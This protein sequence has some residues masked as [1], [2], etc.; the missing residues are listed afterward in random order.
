[1][2]L[3]L[4]ERVHDILLGVYFKHSTDTKRILNELTNCNEKNKRKIGAEGGPEKLIPLPLFY[5]AIV[6]MLNFWGSFPS[7]TWPTELTNALSLDT[8]WTANKL[9][10]A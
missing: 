8:K 6:K 4:G 5:L 9:R 1:M 2:L 10:T 7:P 3:V